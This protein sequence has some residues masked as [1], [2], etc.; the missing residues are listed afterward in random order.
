MKLLKLIDQCHALDILFIFI[1]G[2]SSFNAYDESKPLRVFNEGTPEFIAYFQWYFQEMENCSWEFNGPMCPTEE[3]RMQNEI[4]FVAGIKDPVRNNDKHCSGFTGQ[5]KKLDGEE[6]PRSPYIYH[7]GDL[8]SNCKLTAVR[9]CHLSKALM[10]ACPSLRN[11]PNTQRAKEF[12]Q[13][14]CKLHEVPPELAAIC[15]VEGLTIAQ[16]KCLL[17]ELKFHYDRYNETESYRNKIIVLGYFGKDLLD[18]EC[19]RRADIAYFK[20]DI[21]HYYKAHSRIYPVLDALDPIWLRT[22]DVLKKLEVLLE[23]PFFQA[24]KDVLV[25]WEDTDGNDGHGQFAVMKQHFDKVFF[26]SHFAWKIDAIVKKH[27]LSGPKVLE[28]LMTV[29]WCSDPSRWFKV[30]TDY[31]LMNELPNCCLAWDYL[32]R[33]KAKFPSG[34]NG[35]KLRRFQAPWNF[36]FTKER[37]LNDLFVLWILCKTYGDEK[38]F[39]ASHVTY[40]K[41]MRDIVKLIGYGPLTA[42]HVLHV[43]LL[44]GVFGTHLLGLLQMTEVAQSSETYN[45]LRKHFGIE[46]LDQANQV[47]RALALK[48]N[49]CSRVSEQFTC[50]GLAILEPEQQS[51]KQARQSSQQQVFRKRV[52][53]YDIVPKEMGLIVPEPQEDS[54]NIVLKQV[55]LNNTNP[56]V[57][58]FISPY[59]GCLQKHQSTNQF[60]SEDCWWLGEHRRETSKEELLMRDLSLPKKSKIKR[61]GKAVNP[62]ELQEKLRTGKRRCVSRRQFK[63]VKKLSNDVRIGDYIPSTRNLRSA[64]FRLRRLQEQIQVAPPSPVEAIN[65]SSFGNNGEWKPY[66]F[67]ALLISEVRK[68]L[69]YLNLSNMDKIPFTELVTG[70]ASQ[71]RVHWRFPDG[72]YLDT[73]TDPSYKF[74][75]DQVKLYGAKSTSGYF[76]NRLQA[77]VAF[78][79]HMLLFGSLYDDLYQSVVSPN[80]WLLGLMKDSNGKQLRTV[81]I[82]LKVD[83]KQKSDIYCYFYCWKSDFYI[84]SNAYNDQNNVGGAFNKNLYIC[85]ALDP[86]DV[87]GW[88]VLVT[89]S[90]SSESSN[91][92]QFVGLVTGYNRMRRATLKKKKNQASVVDLWTVRYF[93]HYEGRPTVGNTIRVDV[94]SEDLEK[95]RQQFLDA[96][97]NGEDPEET[98]NEDEDSSNGSEDESV[99]VGCE[100]AI[101]GEGSAIIDGSI[102]Y[103][104]VQYK[105]DSGSELNAADVDFFDIGE[106]DNSDCDM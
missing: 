67:P 22:P 8:E 65:P 57:S 75:M 17:Q 50:K 106:S 2:D 100:V 69:P 11:L 34:I 64:T 15:I 92:Q 3:I 5:N 96:Q 1:Q 44:L 16:T 31:E 55:T 63:R 23:V 32:C 43:G 54:N 35:G 27:D 58:V 104:L 42:Q 30:M 18:E 4:E 7:P 37:V 52:E 19:I 86:D 56:V 77:K 25:E 101:A 95:M 79:L 40:R 93:H 82:Q 81:V 59:P 80:K 46:S 66:A 99:E 71:Y 24:A 85:S 9:M 29:G 103:L 98:S 13:W 76:H 60:S 49:S 84:S 74:S 53:K 6:G 41:L 36:L 89:V 12:A 38:N 47:V 21:G 20:V 94:P 39:G 78:L 83:K 26:Y 91:D 102:E 73:K 105:Q 87:L 33:S 70:G 45:R 90:S 48:Y 97:A 51:N 10:L 72:S 28:L 68:V 61:A 62:Q 14:L 88:K